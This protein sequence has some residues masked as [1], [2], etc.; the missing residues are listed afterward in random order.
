MAWH[1][2]IFWKVNLTLVVMICSQL[3]QHLVL[4]GWRPLFAAEHL[5]ETEFVS[6]IG[7]YQVRKV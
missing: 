3:L 4:L 6:L 2:I 5:P 7:S 1:N